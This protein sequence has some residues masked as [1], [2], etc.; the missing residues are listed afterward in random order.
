M[1]SSVVSSGR[2]AKTS[3]N[4]ALNA[5]NALPI[6]ICR[7]LMPRLRASASASSMLP[8]DEYGLGMETPTTFSG[9][10]RMHRDGGDHGGIDSAAQAEHRGFETALCADNRARLT[11]APSNKS[12]MPIPVRRNCIGR[13]AS[14][15]TIASASG[16]PASCAINSPMRIHRDGVAI[17]DKL[18]VS[19]DGVAVTDRA[20]IGARERGDHLATNGG[21]VQVEGRGAQIHDQFRALLDQAAHRLDVVKRPRQIMFRP[22]IFANG[23]ADFSAAEHRAARPERAGSK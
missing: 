15:S 16:N 6:G 3:A 5:S 13:C 18:V 11:R 22:D 12:A 4:C 17:E 8:R 1:F 19:A 14:V 21:L 20:A 7:H 10:E 23:D 2:P 9:A